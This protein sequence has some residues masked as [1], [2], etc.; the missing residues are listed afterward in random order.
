MQKQ[1]KLPFRRKDQGELYTSMT[2][3]RSALSRPDRIEFREGDACNIEPD[4][5]NFNAILM[6][7]LLC[8]LPDPKASLLSLVENS[9]LASGG[10]LVLVSPYSWLEQYT[11][12]DAWLGAREVNGQKLT[13]DQDI[14]KLLS[15]HFDFVAEDNMPLVIRE[16]ERKYQYIVSHLMV[17]QRKS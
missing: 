16:H 2:A 5:K 8:R 14:R 12:F 7:N 10:L 3:E 17:W 1:G 9:V 6:A 4:L 13:S 15:T 11:Q